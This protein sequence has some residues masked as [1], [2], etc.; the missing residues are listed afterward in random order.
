M[1]HF[2]CKT[3]HFVLR[4][5]WYYRYPGSVLLSTGFVRRFQNAEIGRVRKLIGWTKD[6]LR[7][8]LEEDG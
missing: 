3:H 7:C 8:I 2:S 4:C 5:L 6:A 1:L